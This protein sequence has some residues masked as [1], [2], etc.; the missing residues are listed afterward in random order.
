MLNWQAGTPTETDK[1]LI[2]HKGGEVRVD[3]WYNYLQEWDAHYNE[4]VIAWCKLTDIEPY[5]P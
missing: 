1:Y 3:W 4:D 5:K 2:T